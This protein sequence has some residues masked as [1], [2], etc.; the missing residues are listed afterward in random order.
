MRYSLLTQKRVDFI[1]FKSIIDLIN[2]KEHLTMAGLKKIISIRA[3]MNKGLSDKLI[4]CFPNIIPIDRPTVEFKEIPDSHWLAG[5]SEGEGCFYVGIT[6]NKTTKTGNEVRLRF[7]VAQ[8]SRDYPLMVS[9]INYF[10][11]GKV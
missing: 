9:F 8:H 4:E 10:K 5:F 1:L 6:K 7:S 3:S 2:R 11:C